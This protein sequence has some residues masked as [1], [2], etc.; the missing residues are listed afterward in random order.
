MVG[1]T[2]EGAVVR[3]V[4]LWVGVVI[5]IGLV[6]LSADVRGNPYREARER[7]QDHRR[8]QSGPHMPKTCEG[9][10]KFESLAGTSADFSIQGVRPAMNNHGRVAF[11]AANSTGVERVALAHGG[12]VTSFDVSVWGLKN[13]IAIGLDNASNVAFVASTPTSGSLFGVFATNATGATPTVIYAAE[14][15]GGLSDGGMISTGGQL[16]LAPNGTLAF[17]SI[18]DGAGALY[19]GPV[20]GSL[21]VVTSGSG[22]FFNDQEI[23]VNSPGIIAMQ[24]ENS[25]CGLQRGVLL[26]DTPAPTLDSLMKAVEGLSIGQQ[27]T[28]AINHAGSV[29]LGFS[30]LGT[31]VPIE[32]CAGGPLMTSSV[33]LGVYVATPT[34]FADPADLTLVAASTDGFIDFGEV[35]IDN[36]GGVAFEG[37]LLDGG[38]GIFTGPDPV[39][40][41]IVATGDTLG[42]EFVTDVKLGNLNEA[43]QLSLLTLTSGG[44]RLWRV[45]GV[46]P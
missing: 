38:H 25:A 32:T 13:A 39:A 11:V 8:Q 29:A 6:V 31:T 23:G 12:P 1:E 33:A 27:P 26:F 4:K 46:R 41:K 45:N 5:S 9:P 3:E 42:G 15:G 14:A 10:L 34:P 36:A 37:K 35:T 22:I 20:T 24:M 19:R 16:A 43:C 2:T 28:L 30:G 40:D 18:V 7:R 44:Y 21:T 17:S